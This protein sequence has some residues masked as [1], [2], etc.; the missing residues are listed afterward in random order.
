MFRYTCLN[1]IA[2][3]GLSLF[4]DDYAAVET[5]GKADLV[6]LRSAS[7]HDFDPGENLLAVVRAGAGVNN[8]P[9]ERCS[10]KGIVVF[11]TPGANANAVKELVI[12]A[13][14]YVSR[15]YAGAAAWCTNHAKDPQIQKYAEKEKKRFSGRELAGKRLGVIGLGAIGGRVAETAGHLGMEVYAYDPYQTEKKAQSEQETPQPVRR[16]SDIEQIYRESDMISIHVPLTN[17]TRHMVSAQQIQKMKKGAVLLNFSRDQLVE[18][19]AVLA[20]L[21]QGRLQYYVTDFPNPAVVGQKGCI[22]TPHLGA[23]TFEAEENCAIMAVRQVRDYLENGNIKNSVNYPDCSLGERRSICR[24]AILH[25]NSN[26]IMEVCSAILQKADAQIIERITK[27]LEDRAY[28][29]MDISQIL[30]AETI[31]QIKKIDGV[32]KVRIMK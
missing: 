30:S 26:E 28:S 8:I 29:L 17:E 13:M 23:S 10:Q 7:L 2:K 5:I 12:A 15:D 22:V 20:A 16:V 18:E 3:A 14:L 21:K 9:I 4:T 24:M 32:L 1:P 25:N 19:D 27:G 11:N 6:L 31:S